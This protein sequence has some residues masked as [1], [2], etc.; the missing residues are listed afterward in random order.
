MLDIGR[1]KF[2]IW[3]ML[4]IRRN[5]FLKIA[6]DLIDWRSW[7]SV[8]YYVIVQTKSLFFIALKSYLWWDVPTK[9][10]RKFLKRKHIKYNDTQKL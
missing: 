10:K 4:M 3:L 1:L 2:L 8:A 7:I 6:I 9:G 5:S